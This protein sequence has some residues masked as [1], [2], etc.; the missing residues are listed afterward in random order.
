MHDKCMLHSSIQ[1]S[2]TIRYFTRFLY[3]EK[4][5]EESSR[6]AIALVKMPVLSDTTRFR[7]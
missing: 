1:G 4:S 6:M 5:R 3:S 2:Q 7:G